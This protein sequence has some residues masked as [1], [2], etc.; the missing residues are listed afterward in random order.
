MSE[1]EPSRGSHLSARIEGDGAACPNSRPSPSLSPVRKPRSPGGITAPAL[2]K[3]LALYLALFAAFGAF[4]P[5]LP[6]L[7]SRHGLGPETLGVT[8]AAGT[9]VR[10]LAGPLGGRIADLLAAP[11][12]V[13]CAFTLSAA[14]AGLAFLPARGAWV[15]L[16][17]SV[18]QSFALAPVVPIADTLCLASASP[19]LDPRRKLKGFDYGWVRGAG[20]AAFIVGVT[21][22]GRILGQL[23]FSGIIAVNASLLV[24]AAAIALWVPNRI[25][26]T[27]RSLPEAQ[28]VRSGVAALFGIPIFRRLLLIAALV[29]GSHA[30]HDSFAVINWRADGIDPSTIGIL[31]SEGVAGEIVMFFLLGRPLLAR[32]GPGRSM[33][34]AAAA[35]VIR[36]AV[37]ARA[38]SI[39]PIALVEPLHGFTFALLHLA[40]MHLIR[41]TIPA[42]LAA[43]AQNFYGTFA[44]G[45][46]TA[47]LTLCSGVLYAHLG[48]GGFWVMS[49]LCLL[50]LPLARKLNDGRRTK[51]Q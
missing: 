47:L 48:A 38:A 51:G 7:L 13:L 23:G 50:A 49:A 19:V 11:R 29:E 14:I 43:T 30:M 32:F 18:G 26:T 1:N 34:L 41:E 45:I 25:A 5:F 33:M 44:I 39:V 36:W 16:L 21:L 22:G 31:W 27:Y 15:L 2:A 46:T 12:T 20:S 17:V 35:G 3:F 9:G 4:S 37:L 28:A 6:S 40:C 10:L 42:H 24:A 8:L